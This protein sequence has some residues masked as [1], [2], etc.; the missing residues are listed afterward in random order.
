MRSFSVVSVPVTDQ[1][2]AKQFYVDILGFDLV[3]DA[4]FGDDLRWVQVAPPQAQTSLALVTWFDEMPAGSLRG[5]VLDTDDIEQDYRE[6]RGRGATITA[7]PADQAGGIFC[8]I[9]DPDGNT[10]SLHQRTA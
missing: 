8:F 4:T 9:K 2:R 10:I 6:L 7:P 5:L 1:E 3:A